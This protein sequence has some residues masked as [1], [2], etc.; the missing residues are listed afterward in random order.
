[1]CVCLCVYADPDVLMEEQSEAVHY[2]RPN[3]ESSAG[4]KDQPLRTGSISTRNNSY[5]GKG[6]QFTSE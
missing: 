2:I 6:E 4:P 3:A 1:M 5:I